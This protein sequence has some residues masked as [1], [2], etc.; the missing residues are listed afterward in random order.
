MVILV[1]GII[2][3]AL[4]DNEETTDTPPTTESQKS[5][6]EVNEEPQATEDLESLSVETFAEDVK[7]TIQGAISSQDESITDVTLVNGDL[8]VYVDF[9]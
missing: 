5:Q 1:I 4:G 8:C 9:S 3:G 6:A 7:E 2:G